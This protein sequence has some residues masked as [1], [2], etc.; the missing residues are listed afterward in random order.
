MYATKSAARYAP[1]SARH[2]LVIPR[3]HV[4]EDDDHSGYF[5][6]RQCSRGLFAK[7]L[8]GQERQ[9][10]FGRLSSAA[11]VVEASSCFH[12]RRGRVAKQFLCKAPVNIFDKCTGA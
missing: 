7:H 6:R 4:D 8:V 1:R 11:A 5:R 2:L 10:N 12:F 3:A 9:K